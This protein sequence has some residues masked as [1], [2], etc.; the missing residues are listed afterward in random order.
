MQGRM[1]S[2]GSS[3]SSAI[4]ILPFIRPMGRFFL[5]DSG[6]GGTLQE[7]INEIDNLLAQIFWQPIELH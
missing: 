4:L 6:F 2:S 7:R 1:S 3:K 5:G